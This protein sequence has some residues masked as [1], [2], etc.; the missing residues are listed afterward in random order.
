MRLAAY[1]FADEVE[2]QIE[3]LTNAQLHLRQGTS[4]T[5]QEEWYPIARLGLHLKQ[6]GLKVEVEAFG[7]SGVADGRIYEAGFRNREFDIQVTYVH[8]Y[9]EALRKELMVS[10][11]FTPGAGPIFREKIT[12]AVLATVSAVD[13]D[14]HIR[15]LSIALI[16]RFRKKSAMAYP[17]HTSLVLAFD[18]VK[19]RGRIHWDKLNCSI[20][21][22]G[23]MGGG[24][25]ESVYI[26][27]CATN[28]LQQTS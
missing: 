3:A 22:L 12:G 14:H 16:D 5:L 6:P 8:D 15:K 23:G 20:D 25:F 4:K 17:L 18:D 19:L 2:C 1:A 13:A 27:N 11:G 24:G 9:E 28:E 10:Q 21:L 26:V 7:D